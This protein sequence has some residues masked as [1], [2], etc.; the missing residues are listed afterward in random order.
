MYLKIYS[1]DILWGRALG[2]LRG[3]GGLMLGILR[4]FEG[5]EGKGKFLFYISYQLS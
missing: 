2:V 1:D 5:L 4:G 3:L